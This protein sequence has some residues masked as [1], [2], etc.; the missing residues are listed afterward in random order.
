MNT[1]AQLL[2]GSLSQAVKEVNAKLAKG[3]FRPVQGTSVATTIEPATDYYLAE[4]YHQQV[5][6]DCVNRVDV[7][8]LHCMGVSVYEMAAR[9]IANP[10]HPQ[11]HMS[12]CAVLGTGRPVW[13][14]AERE[15][16][17]DGSYPVL[18]LGA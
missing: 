18:R 17:R 15:Q 10:Y 4:D 1:P 7:V 8:I 9:N 16:G 2:P 11:I 5:W 13:A 14:S 12:L 3:T 6:A